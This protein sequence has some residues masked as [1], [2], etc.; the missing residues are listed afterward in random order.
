MTATVCRGMRL[1]GLP[2]HNACI[3][4]VLLLAA[5]CGGAPPAPVTGAGNNENR[6]P[7]TA[8]LGDTEV[9]ASVVPT[10]ALNDAIAARY[11][12]TRARDRVLV[13]VSLRAGDTARA[14]RVEASARDLR[15]VRQ[16]IE[17]REVR[18]DALVDY[19]GIARVAP[20][21]TLRLEVDVALADGQ[22]TRLRFSRDI[23][24]P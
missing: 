20:P 9:Q 15:G 13:L 19:V 12:V 23:P 24:P 17:F 6:M 21:D 3:A 5:G 11:G 16:S 1:R 22:R 2:L 10:L 18:A 14:G 7:E 4:S 8:T